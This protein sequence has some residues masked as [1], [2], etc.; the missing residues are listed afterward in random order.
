M[1]D[2]YLFSNLWPE[3][4]GLLRTIWISV[5]G[6]FER[7]PK[8]YAQ[9]DKGMRFKNC[10]TISDNPKIIKGKKYIDSKEFKLIKKW[11]LLNN[12]VLLDHWHGRNDTK[13]TVDSM[14]KI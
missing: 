8:L 5:K 14:K 4:T 10:I 13:G 6:K 1:K 7:L 2:F 3:T 11:I 9:I 12:E